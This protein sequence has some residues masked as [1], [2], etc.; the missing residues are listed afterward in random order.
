M[1]SAP[2]VLGRNGHV[3]Y[4]GTRARHCVNS[5]HRLLAR[6]HVDEV[7]HIW[8]YVIGAAAVYDESNVTIRV[9]HALYVPFVMARVTRGKE[10]A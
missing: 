10:R 1:K 5:G 4:C 7:V 9:G 8:M 3:A 2:I 6:T